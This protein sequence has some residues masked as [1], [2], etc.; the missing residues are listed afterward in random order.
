MSVITLLTL[1][2][3]II[4]TMSSLA[5]LLQQQIQVSCGRLLV[6]GQYIGLV[7][8]MFPMIDYKKSL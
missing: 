1:L 3:V 4:M 8:A 2:Q 7:R 5:V 6:S